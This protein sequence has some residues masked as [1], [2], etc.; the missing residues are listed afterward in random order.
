MG[1][2][3]GDRNLRCLRCDTEMLFAKRE[4]IQLGKQSFWHDWNHLLHGSLDVDIYVCPKCGKMEFFA[5]EVYVSR[6][7]GSEQ[8]KTDAAAR[9]AK[10]GA[11]VAMKCSE[12]GRLMPQ[13]IT[14]CTSCGEEGLL[15][16]QVKCPACGTIHDFDD[17]VCPY[18]KKHFGQ[19]PD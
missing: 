17:P 9:E 6:W 12:C 3:M 7:A 8:A 10:P 14:Y 15:I 4:D 2:A 5:P 1:K 19:N 11:A 13:G 18:C 16:P